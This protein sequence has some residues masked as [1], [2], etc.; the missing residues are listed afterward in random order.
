MTLSLLNKTSLIGAMTAITLTT[1]SAPPV[2]AQT[3]GHTSVTTEIVGSKGN[4]D[5]NGYYYDPCQRSTV[6]RTTSG[7]LLGA[8]L[9]AAV[10]AGVAGKHNK[11]EGAVLGGLLGAAVGATAGNSSA[12]CEPTSRPAPVRTYG[13]GYGSERDRSVTIYESR[14]YYPRHRQHGYTRGWDR[15]WDHDRD[16]DRSYGRRIAERPAADSCTLA[17]SP[18]YLPDGRVQKR[19]VRVCPDAY[20]NFQVVE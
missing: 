20:G 5:E 4:Y 13:S 14:T 3:A 16:Y 11:T 10:G 8:A 17:E 2:A 7:G 9:G 15:D 19:F 1:L 6:K 18:I 12:A